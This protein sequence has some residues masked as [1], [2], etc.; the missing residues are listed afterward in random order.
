MKGT[1]PGGRHDLTRMHDVFGRKNPED[2]PV[3]S[4]SDDTIL[5]FPYHFDEICLITMGSGTQYL[6]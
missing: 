2:G 6:Y 1:R 5:G 3:L 4:R